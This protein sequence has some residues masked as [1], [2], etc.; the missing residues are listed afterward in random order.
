MYV[1]TRTRLLRRERRPLRSIVEQWCL[2]SYALLLFRC[3]QVALVPV[4]RTLYSFARPLFI[5]AEYLQ[6]EK[7]LQ[8][9]MESAKVY[10]DWKKS[11]SELDRLQGRYHWKESSQ[12][13]HYDWRRIRDDLQRF[14]EL[15]DTADVKGIMAYSRSRLL[16]NLVGINE[17]E[18]QGTR[19][20]KKALLFLA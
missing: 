11:A 7:L 20:Q 5:N 10:A 8:H 3:V 4:A 1:D 19:W 18:E 9:R 2:C 16:R 14:R 12:S 6:Q 13:L 15:V 17:S